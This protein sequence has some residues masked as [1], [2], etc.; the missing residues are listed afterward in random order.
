MTC[1]CGY[2]FCWLCGMPWNSG[3][4]SGGPI[5]GYL[6]VRRAMA[7]AVL[8]RGGCRQIDACAALSDGAAAWF[9][10][11]LGPVRFVWWLL[12][13][14]RWL[15]WGITIPL[16]WMLWQAVTLLWHV[17]LAVVRTPLLWAG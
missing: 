15:I 11:S 3:C 7:F 9:W 17:V 10:W 1:E 5:C 2:E 6:L 14:V 13:P 4:P 16:R 8:A 12:T